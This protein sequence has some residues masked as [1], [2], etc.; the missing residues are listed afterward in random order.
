[1]KLGI[2]SWGVALLGLAANTPAGM[3]KSQVRLSDPFIAVFNCIDYTPSPK[4]HTPP[5]RDV[6]QPS[7]IDYTL[8]P[9]PPP[10]QNALVFSAYTPLLSQVDPSRD[11]FP[12]P[13][14]DPE[15][16]SPEE[17]TPLPTSPPFP[18]ADSTRFTLD[19]D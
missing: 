7:E 4:P 3:A 2:A 15:P 1:M 13:A 18:G 16:L 12:Q 5:C 10:D 6:L 11:R 9:T 19:R 8:H 17:E 14:P